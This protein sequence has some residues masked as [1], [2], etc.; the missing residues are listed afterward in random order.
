ELEEQIYRDLAWLGLEW[1]EPV[2]RQS[3]HFA[4]YA[5]A[6][7]RLIDAEIVYPSFM[8]RGEARAYIADAE[9]DGRA[10]PRDPDGAPL[11]PPVDK[12]RPEA[13]RRRRMSEGEPFA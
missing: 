4:D 8:S 13:E 6:L 5:H 2:R 10:W 7:D 1:E 11:F 9:A 12:E 3:E